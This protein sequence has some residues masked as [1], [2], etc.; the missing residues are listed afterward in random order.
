MTDIFTEE[1]HTYRAAKDDHARRITAALIDYAEDTTAKLEEISARHNLPL[2]MVSVYARKYVREEYHRKRGPLPNPKAMSD[3]KRDIVYHL[4]A[5][6]KPKE[7]S[8]E[9]GVS[10]QYVY[11]VQAW[12][13]K[14]NVV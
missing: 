6:A 5:G 1:Y 13:K 8:E 3:K 7:I 10:V 9:V 11:E 4:R 12:A 2:T 14:E